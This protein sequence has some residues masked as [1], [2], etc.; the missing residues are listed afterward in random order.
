MVNRKRWRAKIIA[1]AAQALW[2]R[3]MF[4]NGSVRLVR[5]S[6]VWKGKL[7]PSA[8]SQ[9]YTVEI[10]Y[11]PGKRPVIKVLEPTLIKP[12]GKHLPHVYSGEELCVYFP[13]EWNGDSPLTESIIP[14]TSEWLFH[15]EVWLA[16][17]QWCGGGVHPS[18][19]RKSAV[20]EQQ[21]DQRKD[22]P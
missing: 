21:E 12:E 20:S 1:P 9:E 5:A 22:G 17:G 4:P 15:Y 16:S 7:R 3:K 11:R 2:L 14:W 8:L 10:R 13:G 19:K 6:L 18:I